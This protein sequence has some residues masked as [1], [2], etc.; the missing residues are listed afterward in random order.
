MSAR[1]SSHRQNVYNVEPCNLATFNST[2]PNSADLHFTGE[3][4]NNFISAIGYQQQ[5]IVD[6]T[7]SH[8]YNN[9]LPE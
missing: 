8:V 4:D 6:Q 2:D 9:T 3:V 7:V 1:T 5:E